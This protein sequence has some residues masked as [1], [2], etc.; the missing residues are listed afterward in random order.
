MIQSVETTKE[1]FVVVL[2]LSTRRSKVRRQATESS[3]LSGDLYV[4][5]TGAK[6]AIFRDFVTRVVHNEDLFKTRK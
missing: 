2:R 1:E 5:G 4:P 3:C 6:K